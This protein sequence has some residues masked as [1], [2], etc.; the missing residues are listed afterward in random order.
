MLESGGTSENKARTLILA[1]KKSTETDNRCLEILLNILDEQLPYGIKDKLLSAIRKQLTEKVN[2]CGAV[3]PSP[4]SIQLVP[5]GDLSRES[6]LQQSFLLGRFEDS[7][8]QH[9]HACAVKSLLEKRLK[10]NLE[11]SEKLKDELE[12]LK[13]QNQEAA[14]IH[15]DV[16][17]IQ[18]R[19]TACES[20]ITNLKT[21]MNELDNTIEEQGMQVKRGKNNVLTNTRELFAQLHLAQQEIRKKE[22]MTQKRADEIRLKDLEHKLAIQE[23]EFRIRELEA[24]SKKHKDEQTL[25]IEDIL[26]KEETRQK[27]LEHKIA[28][29]ESRITDLEVESKKHKESFDIHVLTPPDKFSPNNLECLFDQ[30]IYY[31]RHKWES[32]GLHLGFSK[33]ELRNMQQG[34]KSVK[35]EALLSQPQIPIKTIIR[36]DGSDDLLKCLGTLL[37]QWL[38]WYPGDSRGST[39]FATYTS[40]ELALAK[41]EIMA[42]SFLDYTSII[43]YTAKHVPS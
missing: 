31:C 3:V 12:T 7:I 2:S 36:Q 19:L 29:Q 20:E 8:R 16:S 32:L 41:V 23:K 33:E 14:T 9:E 15:N 37:E 18:G 4:Q 22:A 27:S 28:D 38:K 25:A 17:S 43:T 35:V 11:E 5:S 42:S 24:E 40:L 34:G 1:I 10:T 26:A 6:A 39:S 21:R 30:L 13:S